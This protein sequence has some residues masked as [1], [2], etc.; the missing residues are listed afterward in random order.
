MMTFVITSRTTRNAAGGPEGAYD[1]EFE[2][3]LNLIL[4][5]LEKLR[6]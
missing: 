3:G 5:G 1:S 4:D 6:R 2:L